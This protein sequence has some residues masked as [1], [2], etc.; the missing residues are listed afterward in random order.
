MGGLV[1]DIV[2][3]GVEGCGDDVVSGEVGGED[4]LGVFVRYKEGEEGEVWLRR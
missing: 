1:E 4:E 3:C 2:D